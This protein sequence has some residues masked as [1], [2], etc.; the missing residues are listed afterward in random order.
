[1]SIS[2]CYLY[3]GPYDLLIRQHIIFNGSVYITGTDHWTTATVLDQLKRLMSL[4]LSC[5]SEGRKRTRD[6]RRGILPTDTA[7]L[8]RMVMCLWVMD[9]VV[10]RGK[11]YYY[12]SWK[13]LD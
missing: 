9:D 5:H 11:Q 13:E 6:S 12:F 3:S 7:T 10:Y 4:L 1:M 8:R 2:L